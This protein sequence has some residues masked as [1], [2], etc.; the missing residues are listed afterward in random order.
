MPKEMAR[1]LYRIKQIWNCIIGE[2]EDFQN[3]LDTNTVHVLQGR[4]PFR[5]LDDRAYVEAKLLKG[6]ILPA[7]RSPDLQ[8]ELLQRIL[9]VEYIIPS[10]YTFLEETKWLEPGT[11]ILKGVLPTKYNGSLA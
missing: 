7:M 5:S 10:I 8:K 2:R 4:C 11:S 3:M 9:S 6:E 1:Y